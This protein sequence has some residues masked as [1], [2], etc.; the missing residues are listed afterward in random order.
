MPK[1]IFSRIVWLARGTSMGLGLV[2]ML[3]LVF[4]VATMAL[5]AAP[6]DPFKLGKTN[7]I[8]KITSLVGSASTALL[9][10]DNNG[11]GPALDLQVEPN[12][13]P[14]N[15]DSSTVVD[16]LNADKL[17]G[18]DADQVRG[19]RAYARVDVHV[20]SG[21]IPAFDISRSSGF[22][23][24]NSPVTGTYCLT[25]ASGID[26]STLPAVVSV[27]WSTTTDPVGN[28]SAMYEPGGGLNCLDDQFKVKTE[29]QSIVANALDSA[30]ANDIGF[31]IIVP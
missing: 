11:T 26:E 4:G 15:V 14:M 9:K 23:A 3:A 27:D 17:D 25:P 19:A 16:N 13:A 12:T 20:G 2:V 1:T 21:N 29:R 24:V 28:A 8:N 18:L 22:T 10:V 5:A 6:G 31:T 30:P 7:T